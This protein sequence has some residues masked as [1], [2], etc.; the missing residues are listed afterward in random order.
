MISHFADTTHEAILKVGILIQQIVSQSDP[1]FT[2][3]F[4][5]PALAAADTIDSYGEGVLAERRTS[6]ADE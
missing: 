4:G 6:E 2:Y 1:N 5:S 3:D